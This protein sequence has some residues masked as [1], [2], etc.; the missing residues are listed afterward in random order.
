MNLADVMVTAK[1]VYAR[2]GGI[3]EMTLWRW[4]RDERMNFPQPMM[5]NGRRYW[6]LSDLQAWEIARASREA[7]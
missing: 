1:Q 4:L 6:K 7:A 2:Y 5:I 3:S